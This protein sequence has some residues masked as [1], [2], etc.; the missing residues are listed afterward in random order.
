MQTWTL[1]LGL[2]LIIVVGFWTNRLPAQ[3]IFVVPAI[4]YEPAQHPPTGFPFGPKAKP[5]PADHWA[6]RVL[7]NHGV[8]CANDPYVPAFGNLH[9]EIRFIFGSSRTFFDWPY[10]EPCTLGHKHP[11]Q[12]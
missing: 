2:S 10:C 11:Q 5:A 1:R 6:M 9:Y 8:G 12:R 4:P 3:E 7:N